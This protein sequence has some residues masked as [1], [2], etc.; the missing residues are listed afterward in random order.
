MSGMVEEMLLLST[1]GS[2]G[3]GYLG[4]AAV[5]REE[6]D[7][8]DLAATEVER[9]RPRAEAKGLSLAWS[10]G[11]PVILRLDP[12]SAARAIANV[13]ENAVKYTPSGGGIS[14]SMRAARSRVDLIVEDEGI[15]IASADLPR[16][17]DPFYRADAA[18]ASDGGGAGL[19]LA[20]VKR[21]MAEQGGSLE[22]ESESGKG[23]RVR[24]S[25]PR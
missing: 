13:L 23:T 16:V 18:R 14:V 25:F 8:A 9:M 12:R 7:L 3:G 4:G 15:G 2:G 5:A 11:A 17:A 10:A 24:L 20:I 19:G 6:C 21:I 22:I 1:R